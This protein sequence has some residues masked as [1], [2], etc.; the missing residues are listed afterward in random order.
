MPRIRSGELWDSLS[1]ETKRFAHFVIYPGDVR[2]FAVHSGQSVM[3][4]EIDEEKEL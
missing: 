1:D 4:R 2:E 3:V